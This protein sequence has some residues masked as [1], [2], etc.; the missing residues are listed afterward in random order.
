MKKKIMSI[1]LAA[2]MLLSAMSITA[3]ARTAADYLGAVDITVRDSSDRRMGTGTLDFGTVS[4]PGAYASC[5]RTSSASGTYSR[6][7]VKLESWYNGDSEAVA[8]TRWSFSTGTA[9]TYI[10]VS[11]AA[12]YVH[13]YWA[14]CGSSVLGS[15]PQYDNEYDWYNY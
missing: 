12:D 8:D 9:N 10:S 1:V 11:D 6:A 3:S 4:E 5:V 7:A 13:G 14:V 2:G 15:D